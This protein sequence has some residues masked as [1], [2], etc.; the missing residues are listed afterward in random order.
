MYARQTNEQ[1]KKNKEKEWK[2]KVIPS[3][4]SEDET[5]PDLKADIGSEEEATLQRIK[6]KK[7][8]SASKKRRLPVRH[9]FILN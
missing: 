9:H 1:S 7:G 5:P 6:P 2:E 4:A 8:V 3:S